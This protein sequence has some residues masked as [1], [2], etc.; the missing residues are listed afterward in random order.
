MNSDEEFYFKLNISFIAF[1]SSVEKY[2]AFELVVFSSLSLS[3]P[4]TLRGF[5]T[6]AGYFWFSR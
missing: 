5:V 4:E 6:S 3:L 2:A 1:L